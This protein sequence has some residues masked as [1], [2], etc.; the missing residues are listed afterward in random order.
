MPEI[1]LVAAVRDRVRRANGLIPTNGLQLGQQLETAKEQFANL[2]M[3]STEEG[4][5]IPPTQPSLQS[6][7]RRLAIS[8]S[9]ARCRAENRP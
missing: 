8:A 3:I 6:G 1:T 4:G 7:D 5:E 9:Y 2:P